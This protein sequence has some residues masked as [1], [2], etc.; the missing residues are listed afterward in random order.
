MD[1]APV[2]LGLI[3]AQY[4]PADPNK[5]RHIVQYASRTLSDVESRYSQVEK[6]ALA[7][8]WACEKLHLYLYGSEFDIIT[9]NKATE[10]IFNNP[11]STPKA[12]IER[13]C[14]RLMPYKFNIKHQPGEYNIADYL[15]RNRQKLTSV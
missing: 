4:D 8:V 13:W 1:A 15:S 7:V 3:L 14:L 2:G 9:D 6:E 5:I 12:R 11:R 10:L